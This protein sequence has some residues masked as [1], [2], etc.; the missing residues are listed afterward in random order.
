[1][2][3]YDEQLQQLQ[4]QIARSKQLESMIK[5]LCRQ[6]EVLAAQVQKLE[7]VRLE[8]Q[9]DVDRLEGRSLAAFFYNVIGKKDE[10]LDKERREAYAAGVRYDAAAGELEGVEDDLRRYKA[11]LAALRGCER[12]YREVLKEKADAIKTAGG[13]GGEEILRMEERN[14]FLESQ[15]KELREAISAGNAA[16]ATTQQILSGLDDAEGWGTWDLLGGGLVADF[17]KHSHLDEAQRAVE[18]LQSQL[19]RFRTELADVTIRA[20]MQVN[21]DGF[22]RFADYFFDGLFADWAVLDKISQSKD[23]M[24]N[25][26]QKI[27]SVLSRLKAMMRSVEQE[28]TQM[29]RKMDALVMQ[30]RL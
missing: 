1:M 13:P 24:Q 16:L 22:L 20:D 17:V 8:E 6:K 7:S 18:R 29:K 12:K 25:T 5:E 30:A 14:A 4:G 23:Q 28:Q 26:K 9:A 2:I 15:K 27:E 3:H 10:Q 11:E 19:R 21:V